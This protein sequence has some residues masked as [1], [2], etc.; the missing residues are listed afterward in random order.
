MLLL[1]GAAS[2]ALTSSEPK[3][4]YNH[5]QVPCGIFDDPAIVSELRQACTTIRKAMRSSRALH[6]TMGSDLLSLN[7]TI[8]WINTKE[9]HCCK[10][11]S[12]VSEYC[13]CQR[14]KRGNFKSESDYLQALKIHHVVMQAAMKAKQSMDESDCVAL[15]HAVEDLSKMYTK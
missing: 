6:E 8:R 4:T 11:I 3:V 12:L 10:I 5:C 14:V 7:Q 9:E 2:V 15:E 1:F 13:L